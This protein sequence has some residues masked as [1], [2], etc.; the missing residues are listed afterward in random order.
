MRLVSHIWSGKNWTLGDATI[1]C[2]CGNIFSVEK[3]VLQDI[4]ECPK[5]GRQEKYVSCRYA[6]YG[7]MPKFEEATTS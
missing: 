2:S 4:I 5:C 7:L 3:L 6:S 1:E